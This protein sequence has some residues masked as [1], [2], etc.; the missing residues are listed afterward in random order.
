MTKAQNFIGEDRK[1]F[2]WRGDTTHTFLMGEQM[3]WGKDAKL[4]PK[5]FKT[6]VRSVSPTS[7]SESVRENIPKNITITR[8]H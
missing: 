7:S 3:G 2:T 4:N 6:V 5:S 1:T 8:G